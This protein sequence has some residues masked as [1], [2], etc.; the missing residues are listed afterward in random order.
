MWMPSRSP[1]LISLFSDGDRWRCHG[2]AIGA[3]KEYLGVD[4][5]RVSS[6]PVVR[7]VVKDNIRV[8]AARYQG[9]P[10]KCCS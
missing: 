8:V 2:A 1:F 3:G 7:V 5:T 10:R 9:C 4:A 6:V